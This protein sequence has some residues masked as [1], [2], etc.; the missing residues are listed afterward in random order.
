LTTGTTTASSTPS[1]VR[2]DAGAAASEDRVAAAA[3]AAAGGAIA[4]FEGL[5]TDFETR[6]DSLYRALQFS[7]T[8]PAW[9]VFGRPVDQDARIVC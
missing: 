8:S 9:L 2:V 7:I 1:P 5:I 6:A 3:A 4:A